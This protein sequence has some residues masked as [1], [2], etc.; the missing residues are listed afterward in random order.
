MRQQ[1]QLLEQQQ[2]EREEEQ[3]ERERELEKD[4]EHRDDADYMPLEQRLVPVLP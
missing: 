4:W 2:R 3:R 1:Q